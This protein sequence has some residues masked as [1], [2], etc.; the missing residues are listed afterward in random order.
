MAPQ[1]F[2]AET[3]KSSGAFNSIQDWINFVGEMAK[4][5]MRPS[6]IAITLAGIKFPQLKNQKAA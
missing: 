1:Y 2:T 4:Q 6:G 3:A 5:N